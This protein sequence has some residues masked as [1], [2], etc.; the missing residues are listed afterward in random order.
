MSDT[1]I[2][3]ENL[4][5]RYLVGHQSAKRERYIALRDVI[6]RE[7]RN[8]A[9]KAVDFVRGRQ[10]VQGDEVEE[11]WALKDVSFEVKRGEV[12]GIIGRNGAGKSTLLKILSRITEPDR[13][14]AILRGRVA[15]LLEVGTGFHPEL[16]GRENI[17]LNG[18]ILGMTRTEIVR[19]FDEI[20]AFAEVERFLDTPVKRYSSGMYLR[21]AFAVAA[22]LESEILIVDEVLA[23]GDAEFQKKCLGKM[24]DVASK[25]GRTVLF[26]SHNMGAVKTLTQRCLYL[27]RGSIAGSGLT[28][29]V[30]EE[31]LLGSLERDDNANYDINLYRQTQR[32]ESPVRIRRIN[33]AAVKHSAGPV[34]ILD[35]NSNFTI[36]VE[37]D[38][39]KSLRDVHV[40]IFLKN[41]KGD[42]VVLIVSV[43]S[44][45]VFSFEPGLHKISAQIKELP[46]APEKYFAEVG[47]GKPWQAY[48]DVII[49]FPV[50][51]VVNHGQVVFWPE[52]PWGIL[53]CSSVKWEVNTHLLAN[54]PQTIS[55]YKTLYSH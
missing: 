31:Y 1:V 54:T 18:A 30:V 35:I 28:P 36:E 5:K 39:S 11:F 20:V 47:V 55:K 37:L 7:A 6:G 25:Q 23:V 38:V 3:V 49:D 32:N 9:R 15:S 17:F 22:H 33:V 2:T 43:D 8:F 53:H 14:R 19:R 50:F 51:H 46:L 27:N 29:K 12:L 45:R 24:Q 26:V 40:S 21:L 52:R 4:S 10:I 48:Y 13:G 42:T 34:P 41:S 44:D 16:T